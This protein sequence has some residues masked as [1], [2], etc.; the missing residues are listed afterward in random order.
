MRKDEVGGHPS[1][2][3]QGEV[4]GD[5]ARLTFWTWPGYFGGM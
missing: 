1:F 5:D 2:G 4:F 3:V